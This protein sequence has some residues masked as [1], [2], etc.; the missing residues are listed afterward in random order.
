MRSNLVVVPAPD[1]DQYLRFGATAKPL[2]AQ[3][4]VA[5]LVVEA[6]VQSILPRLTRIDQR[7]VDVARAEPP[8]NRTRD[9]LRAV[10]RAQEARRAMHADQ[11][12]EHVDHLA[13]ANG[14]G[15]SDC[16]ALPRPLVD[17]GEALQLLSIRAAIE[18][19]IVGPHLI[20]AARRRRPRATARGAP[21]D[22][23]ARHLEA[24]L[25]PKPIRPISAHGKTL[26]PEEHLDPP[27]AV[28]GVLTRELLH[29]LEHRCI[30][31]R[32]P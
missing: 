5:E 25:T 29:G 4:L 14:G 24:R 12:T 8:Q 17:D 13:R 23:A 28:A 16:Q 30:P 2:E 1:L 11:P 21:S 9:E 7:R 10:V 20:R 31:L 6:F 3:A 26:A 22:L 32:K 27:I 15:H 18:D 19:E